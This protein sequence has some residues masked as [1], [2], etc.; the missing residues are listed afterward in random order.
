M[1]KKA[2]YLLLTLV[3]S[4]TSWSTHLVGGYTSYTY[5]TTNADG[6]FKYRLDL[7]LFRD[8]KPS[9][10]DFVKTIE[11]GLYKDAALQD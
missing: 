9:S 8:C 10:A 7:N 5:L 6:T 2:T 4:K 3:L 11:I 1:I